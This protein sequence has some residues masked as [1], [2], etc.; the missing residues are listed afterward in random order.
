MAEMIILPEDN[1]LSRAN[2]LADK[3]AK[4]DHMHERYTAVASSIKGYIAKIEE[5]LEKLDP[6]VNKRTHGHRKS[7]NSEINEQV[8]EQ[9]KKLQL[10][11]T[12][13]MVSLRKDYPNMPED[14]L[15]YLIYTKLRKLRGI[16][17]RKDGMHII[18]YMQKEI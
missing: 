13:S 15:K 10:G 9:A 12:V 8:E 18:L 3:A 14:R 5:E 2:E 17:V 16:Q 4:Y 11:M 7:S 6:L 1:F